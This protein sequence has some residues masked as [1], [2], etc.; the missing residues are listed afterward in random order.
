MNNGCLIFISEK[1]NTKIIDTIYNYLKT[2][3]DDVFFVSEWADIVL[4]IYYSILPSFYM[5]FYC[6][7][8]VFL[9]YS[10]YLE[11]KDQIISKNIYLLNNDNESEQSNIDPNCNI[12]YVSEQGINIQCNTQT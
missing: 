2:K 5:R 4:P 11:H 1:N 7:G 10:D 8:V 9:G 3:Y 12:I 6:G